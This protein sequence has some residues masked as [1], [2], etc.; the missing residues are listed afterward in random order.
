MAVF[1][2]DRHRSL[3]QLLRVWMTPQFVGAAGGH[4]GREGD[5]SDGSRIGVY[6]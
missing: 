6:R 4:D 3:R 1:Q 2:T 5:L